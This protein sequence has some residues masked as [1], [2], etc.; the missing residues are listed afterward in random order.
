[1]GHQE[2]K[3]N[4]NVYVLGGGIGAGKST[5]LEE[6]EKAG[7]AVIQADFIGHDVLAAA[8][9]S[10]RRVMARWPEVVVDGEVDRAALARIV[11]ND[12]DALDELESITHPAIQEGILAAVEATLDD[13]SIRGAII[14]VPLLRVLPRSD[15][16][17]IAVVAPEDLRVSRAVERGAD[18]ADIRAR[19]ANQEP[20]EAWAEW[21]DVIVDNAGPLS[22]TLEAVARIIEG[23]SALGV[24]GRTSSSG[25]A[26]EVD[27]EVDDE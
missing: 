14:E 26:T 22:E 4:A 9:P 15:W 11:F 21:A 2:T 24:P 17:H 20:D 3:E 19:I 23:S 13:P 18:E 10:G 5:V 27:R 6:F 1:M 12:P 16:A 8:T 25:V 7:F